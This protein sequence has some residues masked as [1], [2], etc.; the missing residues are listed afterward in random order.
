MATIG[1]YVKEQITALRLPIGTNKL[2][3]MFMKNEVVS[4]ANVTIENAET[5]D[6]AI[7]NVIPELLLVPDKQTGDTSIKWDKDAIIN[8]YN[9][10]TSELGLPNLL[11]QEN[12]INDASIYW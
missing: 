9:L 11:S 7:L 1:D 3:M 12:S 6:I 10:K 5:M 4:T 2:E 8:Y